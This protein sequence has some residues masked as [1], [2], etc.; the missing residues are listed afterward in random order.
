MK[1]INVLVTGAGGPLGQSIMK[2][3]KR[4]DLPCRIVATDRQP[5]SVGFQWSD[6]Y[7]V[8]PSAEELEYLPRLRSLCRS[9]SVDAILIGSEGEMHV[10]AGVKDSFERETGTKA[11]VSPP[12]VLKISSDKWETVNFL[13]SNRLNHP[14][15]AIPEEVDQLESLVSDLGF[16]LIVK[17][18]VS[19]GSKGMFKVYNRHELEATLRLVKQPVVQEYLQPDDEEYT[20]AVFVDQDGQTQGSIVMWRELAAGLTYRAKV[21]ENRI[22]ADTAVAVANALKPL[23]PCNVQLRLTQRGPVPFEINARFSST[24]SIRAYFGYNEVEMALRSY[25]MGERILPPKP[26]SGIALR[27]WEELYLADKN[28][29]GTTPTTIDVG[30]EFPKPSADLKDKDHDPV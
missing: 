5:L 28:T 14:R 7:Y 3:T 8:L 27:F 15:S 9:E 10:L 24:T 29:I 2:A 25:V 4:A 21:V 17:P 30:Y 18:R 23:G 12:E 26:R 19:S 13:A 6:C 20:C 11:I 22:V 1:T 16:P